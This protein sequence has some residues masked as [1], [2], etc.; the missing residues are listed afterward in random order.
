MWGLKIYIFVAVRI[1]KLCIYAYIYIAFLTAISLET[2]IPKTLK[3]RIFN[4]Y[5]VKHT[6][7]ELFEAFN[8]VQSALFPEIPTD[9]L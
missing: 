5:T 1:E 3:A 7:Y 4:K 2:S 6:S 9:I 8:H